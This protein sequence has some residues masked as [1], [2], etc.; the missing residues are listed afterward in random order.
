VPSEQ[1][2][3][4]KEPLVAEKE[5]TWQLKQE[6]AAVKSANEPAKHCRQNDLPKEFW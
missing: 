3:Q 2:E 6:E 4:A 1:D 5:P